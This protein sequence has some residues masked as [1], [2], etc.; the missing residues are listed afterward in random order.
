MLEKFPRTAAIFLLTTGCS[1]AIPQMHESAI[2][3]K[4]DRERKL[5]ISKKEKLPLTDLRNR[6]EEAKRQGKDSDILT[7]CEKICHDYK[8]S[9]VAPEAFFE[10]GLVYERSRRFTLAIRMFT[11]VVERYPESRW[12]RAS[13]DKYFEIAKKLQSGERPYYFGKIPGFRDYDSAIKNY[14]LIVKYAPYSHYAPMALLEIALLQEQAKHYDLAIDA[15]DRIIDVYPDSKEVPQAYLKT[16]EIYASM[17]KGLEYNQGG[18]LAAKRYYEEFLSIFPRH[19]QADFARQRILDMQESI[20]GSMVALGDYYFNAE[21]NAKAAIKFYQLAIDIAHESKAAEM[22]HFQINY[23]REGGKPKSTFLD[24]LFPRYKPDP[25]LLNPKA[26]EE[27]DVIREEENEL[28]N[29]E[30]AEISEKKFSKK[31]QTKRSKGR[32]KW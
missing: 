28:N 5:A 12:F 7:V 10:R 9:S 32:G 24:P 26:S 25:E 15:L 18:S 14:E 16:A 8:E 22:A 31:K 1:F 29:V 13:I 4:S 2:K 27:I 17:A 21:H 3:S 23:I 19:E 20:A 11:K 6:W 30:E